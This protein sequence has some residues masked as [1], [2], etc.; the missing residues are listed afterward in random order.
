[1]FGFLNI[2]KPPGPTSHD[3][4]AKVRRMCPK[5]TKV[6]HAGTLDPFAGGVLVICVG[7]ATRLAEFVQRQAK[8]YSAVLALGSTSSTD[9][10]DGEIEPV[11]GAEVPDGNRVKDVLK[12]MTGLISQVPPAH[13]A[14]HMNGQRAYRLAREGREVDLPAREVRIDAIEL[15]DYE[16][17]RLEIDVMCGTG[18][19]IRSLA[20]DMG[21]S[22]GCGAYC[23]ELRRTAVGRFE[24]ADSISPDNQDLSGHILSPAEW[25]NLAIIEIDEKEA[26]TVSMGRKIANTGHKK[27]E[28]VALV[29]PSGRLAAIATVSEDLKS[30]KPDKV[31]SEQ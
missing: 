20:R 17:P 24:I 16:Y 10:P 5:G 19:Y 23:A 6:G 2:D 25:L 31:F 22:L 18:T 9:D 26:G 30:I 4:V 11:E 14:V 3:M 1:M 28:Q 21:V 13:S 15:L 8:R 7:P 12:Q 29:D 27:V